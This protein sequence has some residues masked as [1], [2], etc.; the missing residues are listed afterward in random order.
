[1]ALKLTVNQADARK[2]SRDLRAYGERLFDAK[3]RRLLEIAPG[4]TPKRTGN[5]SRGFYLENHND[6]ATIGNRVSYFGR[7]E[8]GASRQAPDGIWRPSLSKVFR[9]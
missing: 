6:G 2:V 5:A 1:M 4:E 3:A 9:K 7:L 8:G